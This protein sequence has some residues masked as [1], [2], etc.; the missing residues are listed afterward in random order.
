MAERENLKATEEDVDR[1]IEKI[2][3]LR[4]AEPSQIYAS[5]QKANRLGELERGVTEDKV[6]EY[7][8]NQST[9]FDETD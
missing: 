6:F 8:L 9:T 3:E 4:K 1:R 7:L 5:L 2:A